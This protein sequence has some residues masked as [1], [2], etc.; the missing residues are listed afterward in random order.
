M[1]I[2]YHVKGELLQFNVAQLLKEKVEASR[3]YEIE[4]AIVPVDDLAL[5]VT[6]P[7]TGRI[8]LV[9]VETNVLVTGTLRTTL[10][11]PCTR[12]L[13]PVEAPV[14]VEI[15]ETFVPVSDVSVGNP[16]VI[17][18][19]V[20]RATLIDESHIL[21]LTEVVRQNLFVSQPTH[22]LCREDCKGLC[23]TCGHNL[24]EGRCDCQNTTIDSRWSALLA[25]KDD[26][27]H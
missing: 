2:A 23:S 26:T 19:D 22:I 13:E 6:A 20:D 3:T 27:S 5:T 24:N 10:K 9:R 1:A 25:L 18:D 17:A 8:R 7:I 12:C 14:T 4:N 11:L 15:E 21:D 16:V